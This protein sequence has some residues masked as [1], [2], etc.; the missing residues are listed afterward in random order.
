[1]N[2]IDL[3][4]Q[5]FDDTGHSGIAVKSPEDESDVNAYA[6]VITIFTP[7]VAW[8]R[9]LVS[10][11]AYRYPSSVGFHGLRIHNS[12]IYKNLPNKAISKE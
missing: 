3:Y 8:E 2:Q 1:M 12:Q 10:V 9:L 5:F 11:D 6:L 4:I 7:Y